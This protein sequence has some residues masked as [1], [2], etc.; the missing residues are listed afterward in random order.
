MNHYNINE[1]LNQIT[2][3]DKRFYL[4]NNTNTFVP[5]V[6]TILNYYPKDQFLIKWIREQG[7]E[8]L[9]KFKKAGEEGGLVH[10]LTEELDK[11]QTLDIRNLN[12]QDQ[13]IS[14]WNSL[15]RYV[16]FR[17]QEDNLIPTEIEEPFVCIDNAFKFGGTIDRVVTNKVTNERFILDIKT[18]KSIYPYFWVQLG[19]YTRA[20]ELRTGHKITDTCILHLKALTRTNKPYQ[21]KGWKLSFCKPTTGKTWHEFYEIFKMTYKFY[22]LQNENTKPNNT[23]LNLKLKLNDNIDIQKTT[24]ENPHFP[25]TNQ[26]EIPKIKS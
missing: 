11:G 7:Q 6:T 25:I 18:S 26:K 24:T 23:T 19:A 13:P 16:E 1:N 22:E 4:D 2:F 9:E 3:T 8:G 12:L 14:V 5:S 20:Y 15:E 10:D 21:G 17:N